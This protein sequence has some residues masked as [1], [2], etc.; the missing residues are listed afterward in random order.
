[1]K[2]TGNTI[3]ITGGGSGIGRA[4]AHRWH[5]E[6]NRVIVAGRRREALEETVAGRSGMAYY[7]LDVSD[8]DAIRSVAGRLTTDHPGLNVL[9]NCA[10]ISGLEDPTTT[11]DLSRT[12]DIVETNL[13]GPIRMTDALVDHLKGQP[14]AAI[15]VVSSGTGF[16]PY[17]GA[18]TYSASKAAIHSYTLS[19]RALLKGATQVIEIIPPMVA[20]DLLDGLT[21][22]P[23]SVPLDKFADDVMAQ[24]TGQPEADEIIVEEVEPFRFAERD[25][26]M[27]E[28]VASMIADD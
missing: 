7:E 21:A 18:A 25:G 23:L 28:I 2:R 6:G 24:L 22:S 26:K 27:R 3:F 12:S 10:G 11:R 19:L 17:P 16:V 14:D 4:L 15:L 8:P 20:T 13:L 5:D 1:M 9:V